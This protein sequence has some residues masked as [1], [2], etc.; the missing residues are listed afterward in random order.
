MPGYLHLTRS[1]RDQ[2]ADL[3]AQ[4]LGV[5]WIG[6]PS[7]RFSIEPFGPK[8]VQ[9]CTRRI[10]MHIAGCDDCVMTFG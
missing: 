4:G 2:V 10:A 6:C 3:N 7:C 9:N 5:K 8:M 1:E